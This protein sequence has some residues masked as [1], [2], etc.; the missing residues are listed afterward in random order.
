MPRQTSQLSDAFVRAVKPAD[1]EKNYGDGQ[2]L[3]LRVKIS[4]GKLWIFNYYHPYTKKRVYLSLGIYPDISL[5]R[6]RELRAE[7][8]DLLSRGIDPKEA[9]AEREQREQQAHA[10]TLKKVFE[11]WL[12]VKKTK[13][14]DDYAT[15][16]A[17]SLENHVFP[18]LGE[19]PIHKIT[20][21]QTIAILKPIA[22]KGHLETIKR[23]CQRLNEIMVYAKN[24]GIIE[25][26]PLSGIGKAFSN[27]EV[28]NMPTLTPEQLPE[29]MNALS[30]ASIK[31]T[32]R[33]LIAW[34]LHTMT[35]PSEAAGARWD[36][37]N[38]DQAVWVIPAERMKKRKTHIIPLTRESMALLEI[39][40]PI[41]GHTTFIFPGDRN[42]NRPTHSQT[43]NMALKRMGFEKT[44]VS[45]GLRALAST[46]LNEHGFNPDWIESA[47]AHIGENSV[48]E[49]YNHA[50]YV[51]SRREMM[52]WW[53]NRITKACHVAPIPFFNQFGQLNPV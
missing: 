42:P 15:D 47:L 2:G 20:A 26:N 27:P 7:A 52:Q 25:Q 1:N 36:E 50:K 23:L 14:T 9:R 32:T 11:Q 12:A 19:Y 37:I 8:K 10:N 24:A 5:K 41:S 35:R 13:V 17:R 16:I 45:H 40:R 43:A 33:C 3:F 31:L 29:L 53:S 49:A 46:T 38:R 6:A 34:Q 44:L 4:G 28:R 51:E 48:R 18:H 30:M 39:M 21:A 22:A